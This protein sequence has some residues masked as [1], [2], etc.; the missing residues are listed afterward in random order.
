MQVMYSCCAGIDVHAQT[1]LVCLLKDDAKTV[2]TFSTMTDDLLALLDW[3][4]AEGSITVI[5]AKNVPGRRPTFEIVSG[6]TN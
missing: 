5:L 6:L 2:R 3:L 4:T 1:A